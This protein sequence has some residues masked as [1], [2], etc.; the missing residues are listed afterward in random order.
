MKKLMN[1]ICLVDEFIKQSRIDV[2]S[3]YFILLPITLTFLVAT[4]IFLIIKMKVLAIIS[5][6]VAFL[7]LF[8]SLAL[9]T[10]LLLVR[11]I[12]TI[13]EYKEFKKENN[14]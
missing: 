2:G 9:F 14:V 4:V 7:S 11:I 5:I 3:L 13:K 6:F 10:T 12:V 8:S 1:K